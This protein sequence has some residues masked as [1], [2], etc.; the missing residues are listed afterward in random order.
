MIRVATPL[1]AVVLLAAEPSVAQEVLSLA[2]ESPSGI[3]DARTIEA[4]RQMR[5]QEQARKFV[6]DFDEDGLDEM[7]LVRKDPEGHITGLLLA[8]F[9]EG[10]T[11]LTR[12]VDQL[13]PALGL[14]VGNLGFYRLLRDTS[15]DAVLEIGSDIGVFS[16]VLDP[17]PRMELRWRLSEVSSRPAK[18]LAVDDYTGDGHDDLV[19]GLVNPDTGQYENGPVQVWTD[20]RPLN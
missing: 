13:P 5:R 2:W 8:K 9:S 15:F 7:V 10:G 11:V 6:D 16:M 4:N 17:T 20:M 19:L 18:L 3:V 12:Q 14:F 1:L